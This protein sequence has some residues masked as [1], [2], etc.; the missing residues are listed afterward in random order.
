MRYEVN[1]VIVGLVRLMRVAS[2]KGAGVLLL[3]SKDCPATAG[4]GKK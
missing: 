1:A 4:S 3:G 2:N